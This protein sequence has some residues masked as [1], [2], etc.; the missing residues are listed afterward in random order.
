M[1]VHFDVE[2]VFIFSFYPTIFGYVN[3][4]IQASPTA[5]KAIFEFVETPT[6]AVTILTMLMFDL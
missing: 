1:T 6:V 3:R 2:L 4:V 5:L